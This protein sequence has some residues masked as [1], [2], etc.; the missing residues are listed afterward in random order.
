LILSDKLGQH[1]PLNR[2]RERFALE[3]VSISLS[4]AA[5]AIGSLSRQPR[6]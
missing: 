4:T 5:D 6:E 3:G 1:I 2:Q